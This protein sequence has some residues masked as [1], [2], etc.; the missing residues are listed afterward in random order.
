[1]AFY[2]VRFNEIEL[3]M[4]FRSSVQWLNIWS[5]ERK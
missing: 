3:A 4:E 5:A 2:L 1:M